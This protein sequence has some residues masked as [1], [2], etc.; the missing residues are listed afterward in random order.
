L[1]R[2]KLLVDEQNRHDSCTAMS[3]IRCKWRANGSLSNAT[4]I[5]VPRS[6]SI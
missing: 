3:C 1:S 6:M 2:I 5:N 4:G